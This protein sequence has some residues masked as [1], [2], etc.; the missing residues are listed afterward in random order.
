MDVLIKALEIPET[1]DVVSQTVVEIWHNIT[2]KS[3]QETWKLYYDI[4]AGR[5]FRVLK[6]HNRVG[7]NTEARRQ[8]FL[9]IAHFTRALVE[10]VSSIQSRAVT[11]ILVK[12]SEELQVLLR[13]SRSPAELEL[14]ISGLAEYLAAGYSLPRPGLVF[15]GRAC[16][17][18]ISGSHEQPMKPQLARSLAFAATVCLGHLAK[19][20]RGGEPTT[21]GSDAG[22]LPPL[23]TIFI[24]SDDAVENALD[25]VPREERGE[26][27][28]L[29]V[30][31]KTA[32]EGSV[33]DPEAF[34][35]EMAEALITTPFRMACAGVNIKELLEDIDKDGLCDYIKRWTKRVCDLAQHEVLDAEAK[36]IITEHLPPLVEDATL[37][38]DFFKD[39]PG[40]AEVLNEGRW[41]RL[42]AKRDFKALPDSPFSNGWW[43]R[44]LERPRLEA[45]FQTPLSA[46][47]RAPV[48]QP[49]VPTRTTVAVRSS[50]ESVSTN[51]DVVT[52]EQRHSAAKDADKAAASF[53]GGP[54]RRVGDPRGFSGFWQQLEGKLLRRGWEYG[55]LEHFYLLTSLLPETFVNKAVG[56][57]PPRTRSGFNGAVQTMH[58][59]LVA[60]YGGSVE[61]EK[62]LSRSL[63]RGAKETLTDYI[64]RLDY[65]EDH[66]ATAGAPVPDATL[67]QSSANVGFGTRP[68]NP[69]TRS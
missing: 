64:S 21:S 30:L 29:T 9:V 11:R 65:W 47:S 56:K 35:K 19:F 6:K 52:Q 24:Y 68:Q 66:C 5:L 32:E 38:S 39:L 54:F 14:S 15:L 60:E 23:R 57:V 61:V 27:L 40:S 1:E 16:L 25:I 34:A 45:A 20:V 43:E 4:V 53:S 37:R 18:V 10:S 59:A 51:Q 36:T 8:L 22:T 31:E 3:A 67:V 26:D 7:L 58:D 17:D 69:N 28:L 50:A 49:R 55:G 62:L 46:T 44:S 41:R 42:S 33:V 13:E 2:G 12:H 48:H 63:V